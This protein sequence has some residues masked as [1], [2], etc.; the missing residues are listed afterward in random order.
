[1]AKKPVKKSAKP[2]PKAKKMT[3]PAAK[4][5]AK[6][7]AKPAAKGSASGQKTRTASK[8]KNTATLGYTMGEFIEN[9]KGFCGF[10]KRAQAKVLA[11]DLALFFTDALRRGYKIP[12]LGLGKL[13]V[14]Q[15]KARVGRNP[16]TG[17]Q[18]NIPAKKRIRFAPAKALKDAVLR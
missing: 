15:T 6:V 12:F 11:E 5:A 2:A 8:P 10:E 13:F 4:P 3:K 1:M 7:V 17:E 14:R 18:I 16:A 9:I